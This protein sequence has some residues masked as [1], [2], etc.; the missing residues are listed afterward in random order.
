MTI[1]MM[2]SLNAS[3]RL[4]SERVALLGR[5]RMRPS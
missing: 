5:L 2:P 1:A 3:A 4:V